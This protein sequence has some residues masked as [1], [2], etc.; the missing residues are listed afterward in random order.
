VLPLRFVSIP[1]RALDSMTNRDFFFP[2][3]ADPFYI[4][5]KFEPQSSRGVLLDEDGGA[6]PHAQV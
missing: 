6:V 2:G 1:G 3:G 4:R 5:R